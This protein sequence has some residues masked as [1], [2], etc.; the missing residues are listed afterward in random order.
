MASQMK[1]CR[2]KTPGGNAARPACPPPS[3]CCHLPLCHLPSFRHS[4]L[5]SLALNAADVNK[6]EGA[7]VL[8]P[9]AGRPS[10]RRSKHQIRMSVIFFFIF[11]H[12]SVMVG[13][14][15]TVVFLA[16]SSLFWLGSSAGSKRPNQEQRVQ[17]FLLRYTI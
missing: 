9:S 6:M 17:L 15:L 11:M 4:L 10:L 14:S 1:S 2:P 3:L 12:L 7:L 13:S 5:V 16:G 8:V